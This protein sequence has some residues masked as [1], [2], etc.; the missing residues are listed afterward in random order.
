M[1]GTPSAGTSLSRE[2]LGEVLDERGKP[3]SQQPATTFAERIQ[4]AIDQ[5]ASLDELRR[6]FHLSESELR[7]YCS[8]IMDDGGDEDWSG[9]ASGY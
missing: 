6:H 3:G 2:I 5:G 4:D 1:A 7:D 9:S 8:D